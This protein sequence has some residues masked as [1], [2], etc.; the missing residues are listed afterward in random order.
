MN[1]TFTDLLAH[2]K[3]TV[4][5][6]RVL[7]A[8]DPGETTGIRVFKGVIAGEYQQV[9]TDTVNGVGQSAL[10]LECLIDRIKPAV[11][12]MEEYRV[13][14]HRTRQHAGSD[15]Y[16][17]R[18]IGALE[19]L[20]SKRGIPLIKQTASQAKRFCTDDKLRMWGFY[21]RGKKHANDATRHGCYYLLFGK[22]TIK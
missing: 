5:Q 12:V 22:A 1:I 19:L 18:L 10:E 3:R 11:I 15:L 13:Y 8:I 4:D 20:I 2:L 7:L 9:K 21:C 17:P 14:A 6:D 16:T